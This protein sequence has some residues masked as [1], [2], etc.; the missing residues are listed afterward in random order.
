[1]RDER[2][3]MKDEKRDGKL[4]LAAGASKKIARGWGFSK[5]L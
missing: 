5:K 4:G 1:M 3:E 2:K